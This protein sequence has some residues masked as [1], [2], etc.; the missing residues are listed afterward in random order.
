M[1]L[2]GLPLSP[3]TRYPLC[4]PYRQCLRQALNTPKSLQTHMYG[5]TGE[6]PF[7]CDVEGCGR[8][9]SAVSNFRRHKKA[10]KGRMPATQNKQPDGIYQKQRADAVTPEIWVCFEY[11]P[12]LLRSEGS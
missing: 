2:I 12:R 6:K 4:I 8:H 9:F 3:G 1:V 7:A 11:L 5:H 10:H